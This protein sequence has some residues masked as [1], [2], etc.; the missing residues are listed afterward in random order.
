MANRQRE[1]EAEES[2]N[3]EDKKVSNE[4]IQ[5]LSFCEE[6]GGII[7]NGDTKGDWE[8]KITYVIEEP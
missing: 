8:K 3:T 7:K 4:G 1:G 6:I 5:L 2:R